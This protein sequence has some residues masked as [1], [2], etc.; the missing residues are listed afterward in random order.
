MNRLGLNRKII[1][2]QPSLFNL[3]QFYTS[4][5]TTEGIR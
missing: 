3:Q 2:Q 4:E 1:Q 5:N